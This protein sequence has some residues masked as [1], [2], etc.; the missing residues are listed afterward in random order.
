MIFIRVLSLDSFLRCIVGVRGA[1]RVVRDAVFAATPG[2]HSQKPLLDAF[3]PPRRPGTRRLEI[4]ARNLRRGWT[5]WGNE[6]RP[7]LPR[8]RRSFPVFCI[9]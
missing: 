9:L 6:A 3:L 2:R 5:S 7:L 4:F 1:A 8:L